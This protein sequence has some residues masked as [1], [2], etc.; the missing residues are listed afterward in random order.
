MLD[1]GMM[2]ENV[3]P[4]NARSW[5]GRALALLSRR[6]RDDLTRLEV[7]IGQKGLIRYLVG[8]DHDPIFC[9]TREE[10]AHQRFAAAVESAYHQLVADLS[11]ARSADQEDKR[12][13]VSGE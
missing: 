4:E 13:R 9:T 3:T 1:L 8:Q 5:C 2:R 11:E 6:D 7:R 10:K 12:R